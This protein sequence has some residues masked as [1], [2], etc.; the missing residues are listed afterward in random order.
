MLWAIVALLACSM[1]VQVALVAFAVAWLESKEAKL[2]M[3]AREAFHT[4]ITAPDE[5]T[6]S[7]LAQ[8]A[9]VVGTL[10]A[11]RFV[12]QIKVMLNG[13]ASGVVREKQAEAISEALSGAPSWMGLLAG[14]LP[15]KLQK[16]LLSRPELL[17]ALSSMAGKGNHTDHQSGGAGS[18]Q[19]RMKYE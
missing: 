16:Q 18:V 12:Q 19:S 7:P 4:L 5:E 13:A 14:L 10:V 3:E 8:Y 17:G 15:K 1:L 6:A 9:D 11:A 2:R